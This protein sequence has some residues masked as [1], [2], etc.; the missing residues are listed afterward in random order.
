VV[1]QVQCWHLDLEGCG[2]D[3]IKVGVGPGCLGANTRILLSNGLYK[4]IVDIKPGDR[5]I[6]MYGKPETVKSVYSTGFRETIS[7]KNG[8][9]F[10]KTII[11]P[12]HQCYIGDLQSCSKNTLATAGYAKILNQ[13]SKT[14]PKKSKFK[15]KP[16][17]Q[18]KNGNAIS[19]EFCGGPHVG[20][21]SEL[22]H[23]KIQK[24]EAVAQGI[25]RIK[26]IL[27]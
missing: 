16:I 15:W 6:S 3:A 2:A 18:S 13:Q 14:I 27:E 25:R 17:S 20:N 8:Q 1:I 21:T 26:A 9:S 11:T 19:K 12:D 5:I 4:N 24:E 22:G 7:I 23:F 10:N